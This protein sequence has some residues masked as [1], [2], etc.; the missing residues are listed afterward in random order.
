MTLS[1]FTVSLSHRELVTEQ[2]AD[3]SLKGLFEQARHDGELWDSMCGYFLQNLLL[4]RK[5][6][7]HSHRFVGDPLFQLVLLSK[8]HQLVLKVL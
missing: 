6:A 7:H 2:K 5:W 1:D 8:L 3:S 4:V